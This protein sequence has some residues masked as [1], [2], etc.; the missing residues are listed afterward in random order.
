MG[1]LSH[2]D[3]YIS[4][5]FLLNS[6]VRTGSIDAPIGR[7]VLK[8]NNL[9]HLQQARSASLLVGFLWLLDKLDSRL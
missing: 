2:C 9:S 7:V 8:G 1:L 4:Y 6:T 3:F 5:S